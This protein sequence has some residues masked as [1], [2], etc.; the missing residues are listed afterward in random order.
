MFI[1]RKKYRLE[2]AH[3]LSTSYSAACH[4]TIHGH[5]YV[6]EVFLRNVHLDQYGMVLDFGAMANVREFLMRHDHALILPPNISST[7]KRQLKKYNKKLIVFPVNPTAEAMAF[8]WYKA[9]N[10]I[11]PYLYAVRV[12]ETE[13]GYAEY[14]ED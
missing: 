2:L 10:K 11:V 8:V 4:E 1:I 14:R 3:I 13:T 7:R 12:H 5:S 9:L 6:V